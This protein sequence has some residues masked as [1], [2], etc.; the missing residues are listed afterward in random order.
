MSSQYPSLKA[1]NTLGLEV[2]T[3]KRIVAETPAAILAAWQVSRSD[4]TPFLVLGEGSNVLF[5]K[6]LPVQW[7]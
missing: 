1:D 7:C 4:Q 5:W 3:Q 6:I 2:H